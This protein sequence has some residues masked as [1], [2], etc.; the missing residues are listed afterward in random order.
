MPE[1]LIKKWREEKREG[2]GQQ[3]SPMANADSD[4]PLPPSVRAKADTC[5]LLTREEEERKREKV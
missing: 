4:S 1:C 3:K 2:I 5:V